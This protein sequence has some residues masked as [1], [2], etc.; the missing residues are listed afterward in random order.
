MGKCPVV[1]NVFVS[2]VPSRQNLVKSEGFWED[3]F[4]PNLGGKEK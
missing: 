4:W 3:F 2:V 1:I